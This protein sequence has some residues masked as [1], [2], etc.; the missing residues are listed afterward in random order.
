MLTIEPTTDSSYIQSVFTNLTIYSAMKDDAC[1]AC[2][3]FAFPALATLGGVFLKV[4][5][6]GADAG[7]FWFRPS[8]KN[9][10]AH[11][12]LLQNCRGRDA[13]QAARMAVEWIFRN[14]DTSRI[15]SY[16]WSDAPAVSWFC[17]KVGLTHTHV[18]PWRNTRNGQPV[19]MAYFQ[20]NREDVI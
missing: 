20:I 16:A 14:T 5:K 3:D 1:P 8:G 13:I 18:E 2:P 9:M 15:T 4:M 12:A 7:V 6:D 10:E 19:N 17:R 11:T